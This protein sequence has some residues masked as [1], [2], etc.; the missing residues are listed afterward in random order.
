VTEQREYTYILKEVWVR[1]GTGAW[2]GHGEHD[3]DVIKILI[4]VILP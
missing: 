1:M 4:T 3:V 2:I